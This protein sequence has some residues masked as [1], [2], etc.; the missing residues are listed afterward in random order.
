MHSLPYLG[1]L[2]STVTA[3]GRQSSEQ[4][5]SWHGLVSSYIQHIPHLGQTGHLSLKVE[6]KASG[7]DDGNRYSIRHLHPG[8]QRHHESAQLVP[9]LSQSFVHCGSHNSVPAARGRG[10][11]V[12]EV[13]VKTPLP[14]GLSVSVCYSCALFPYQLTVCCMLL[15]PCL[16]IID[17]SASRLLSF[18]LSR[19]TIFSALLC[20][21]PPLS[22]RV[23]G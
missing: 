7:H 15:F 17:S 21:S 18:V 11:E 4:L 16:S 6:M 9:S 5:A 19:S 23:S 22:R 2:L 12:V 3:T 20:S 8:H 1:C 14:S 13:A 10:I